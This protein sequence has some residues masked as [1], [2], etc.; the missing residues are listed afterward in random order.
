MRKLSYAITL[1]V[2]SLLTACTTT[3]YTANMAGVSDHATV[4]VKD[5]VTLG[6]VTVQSTE[7]HHSSPFGVSKRIEGSKIT[8]AELLH[9]AARLEA[10]DVINIRIDIHTNF[11]KTAFDW[12][13]GWTRV[14]TY[15]GTALAIR[16]PDKLDSKDVDPQLRGIPK[17]P[18]ESG[19]TQNGANKR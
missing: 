3:D 2:V 16:Y 18:E 13:T 17:E 7:I 19:V 14:Y 10:D 15:T 11:T 4:A 9:E 8:F 5:F 12:L 6:L 1:M